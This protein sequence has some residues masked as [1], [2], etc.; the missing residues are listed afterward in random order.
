M[1]PAHRAQLDSLHKSGPNHP[2]WKG[3]YA[4]ERQARYGTPEYIAFV[5]AVLERDDYT[6]QRCGA[7]NGMGE[8][9][10]L[11][12]HHIKPYA[13]YPELAFDVD[14]GL[15]LCIRCHR[16]AHA[17]IPRPSDPNYHGK[18]RICQ[19]CG[20]EFRIKNGR[21]Y[22]PE[23]RNAFC[24]PVCGSTKCHHSAR[25]LLQQASLFEF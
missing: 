5:T 21:K 12:V 1:T 8:N 3:G 22:C 20:Q 17:G 16:K 19:I 10:Q 6:C 4:K 13:D 15:T 14:N 23:C 25:R 24:C 11:Q 2:N 7:R 18:P 9:V